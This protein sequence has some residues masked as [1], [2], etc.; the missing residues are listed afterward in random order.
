MR[1]R[2]LG[3]TKLKVSEISFGTGDNAGGIIYSTPQEQRALIERALAL[4]ITTF[5]CSPDYGRGLGEANLGR[6]L[7]EL[8]DPEVIITT[9]VEIMPEDVGR[10]RAKT[11][12]SVN[13]SLLRLGRKR[14]DVI[15]LHNPARPQRMSEIR[16]WMPMSPRDIL[17]EV[18]PAFEELRA[19]GK[20]DYFGIACEGCEGPALREV[21]ATR[22]FDSLN[23]HF[24]LANPT[25]AVPLGGF[26]PGENYAGVLD[27]AA[28]FG[29]GVAVIRPLAGGALSG[30]VLEKRAAGRHKYAGG[31]LSSRP[32]LFEPEIVRA[33]RFAFLHRPPEQTISE[34]AVRFILSDARVSTMIGGFSD[35][36][37]MEEGVRAA[38]RGPLSPVDREAVDAVYR[39]AV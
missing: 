29:V 9:K 23:V 28:E 36:A 19:Q 26:A 6:V 4:G 32:E 7:K 22:K 5:D 20:V 17:D 11:I 15:Q 18:L 1:Y 27:A 38:E 25:A 10:I 12:E 14:V 35:I 31:I 34:A 16:K 33:Q 24:N 21:L 13:D 2:T 8:G 30:S 39:A 37:Q 3:T